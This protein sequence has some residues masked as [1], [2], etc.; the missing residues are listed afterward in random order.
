MV[1]EPGHSAKSQS[2]SEIESP[3]T[4]TPT[5]DDGQANRLQK[6]VDRLLKYLPFMAIGHFLVGVPALIV[7]L[8]V[9]YFS[10]VQAEA[11]DKMQVASVWPR[12]SYETS[13]LGENGQDTITMSLI[14][15]GVGPA[16]IR[17]M[18]VEYDDQEFAGFRELLS[19]CCSS[20]PEDL[21]VAI[22]GING[23]V[24]RPGE[25]MVFAQLFPQAE[26]IAA[27]RAFETERLKLEVSV[28]YCSV[29][30]DCWVQTTVEPE[31]A[32][33]AKCPLDWKQYSG[34]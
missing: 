17:G 4:R 11:T 7:S 24:L 9:A 14:N 29:F 27:Y 20:S 28:C 21:S 23:E 31:P 13:N 34:F 2:I 30:E 18:R 12:V 3:E 19:A 8:S 26:N 33:T 10:F 1:S 22:G 6:N 25:R 15:K 32:T 16:T 5:E